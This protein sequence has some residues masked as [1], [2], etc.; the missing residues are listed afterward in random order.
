MTIEKNKVIAKFMGYKT[1]RVIQM[2]FDI[3]VPDD[4]SEEQIKSLFNHLDNKVDDFVDIEG[5]RIGFE[6]IGCFN[7]EDMTET[8]K[9]YF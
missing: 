5:K 6:S 3:K 7:Y 1:P 2:G 8:Y 9:N 4:V